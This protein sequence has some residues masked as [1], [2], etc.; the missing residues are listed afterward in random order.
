MHDLIVIGAGPAGAAAA[1]TAADQGLNVLVLEQNRFPRV[2]TCTGCLSNK[3]LLRLRELG[4]DLPADLVRGR[5]TGISVWVQGI[6][7]HSTADKRDVGVMVDRAVFDQW[8]L[9][10]AEAKGVVFRDRS[11]LRELSRGSD[12]VE[13]T[14]EGGCFNGRWVIGADG[15]GGP[16]AR[17]AGI[18]KRWSWWEMGMTWST[19]LPQPSAADQAILALCNIPTT[20]GWV[21]PRDDGVHIGVG[22]AQILG[23]VLRR[24][25]ERWISTYSAATGIAA[26]ACR[27][28]RY[29]VPAGGFHRRVAAGRVLLAGDAAGLVDPFA[30]EGIH[31][32][33]ASGSAAARCLYQGWHG[34]ASQLY[35]EWADHLLPELRL[36]LWLSMALGTRGPLVGR[37]LCHNDR[38]AEALTSWMAGESSYRQLIAK[39]LVPRP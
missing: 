26:D 27:P 21:F 19:S 17:L 28:V 23:D 4:L 12:H 9:K 29:P 37:A 34:P 2:K 20:W 8:L 38:A 11:P 36:S 7:N 13:V 35:Q 3:S 39:S 16:T 32:A 15:V 31:L 22:G 25:F 24:G 6:S 1:L 5:V 33:L 30:G 14:T 18:R 10:R